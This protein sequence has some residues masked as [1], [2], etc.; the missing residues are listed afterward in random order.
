M[1]RGTRFLTSKL[2]LGL[3]KLMVTKLDVAYFSVAVTAVELLMPLGL[4]SAKRSVR[5]ATHK[6]CNR[7]KLNKVWRG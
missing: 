7:T 5:E 4:A 2:K 1:E 6:E 3:P